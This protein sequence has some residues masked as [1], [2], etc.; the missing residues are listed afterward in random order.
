MVSYDAFVLGS[1]IQES[2]L[3]T[4]ANPTSIQQSTHSIAHRLT[5]Q[6]DEIGNFTIG[7]THGHETDDLPVHFVGQNDF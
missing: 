4:V 1:C 3:R 7:Q 6:V 5:R 2:K